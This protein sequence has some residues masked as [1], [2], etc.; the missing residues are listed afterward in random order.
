MLGAGRAALS[1]LSR[2]FCER[3]SDRHTRELF[4]IDDDDA[5]NQ[6]ITVTRFLKDTYLWNSS[7]L[8][9]AVLKLNTRLMNE[10]EMSKL[11][12]YKE[13]STQKVSTAWIFPFYFQI[14]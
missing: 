8:N 4:R 1:L 9:I 11:Q 12:I 14:P 2:L 7:N 13:L 6:K 5:W 3:A 10:L